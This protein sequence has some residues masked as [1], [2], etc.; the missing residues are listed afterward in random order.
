MNSQTSVIDQQKISLHYYKKI[1]WEWNQRNN[2]I[3]I[4][5]LNI[6]IINLSH[7]NPVILFNWS[8]IN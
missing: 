1:E 6:I 4:L 7:H 2:L 3:I 8:Y 5:S